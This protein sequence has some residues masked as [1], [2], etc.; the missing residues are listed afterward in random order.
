MICDK[1][2][3]LE[4]ARERLRSLETV[5]AEYVKIAPFCLTLSL[6]SAPEE[7]MGVHLK[8]YTWGF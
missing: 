6:H 2:Y 8:F 3:S 1:V 5:L 7:Q 4:H